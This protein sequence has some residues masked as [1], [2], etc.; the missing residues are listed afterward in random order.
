M[1]Y[2]TGVGARIDRPAA[3]KTGTNEKHED[4]WFAGYTP[5]LATTVWV[6]YT[7][8]EIPMENVHGIAVAGGTFPATIWR[9]FM[10]PALDRVP[11]RAFPQP[12]S[13]PVWKPFTRGRYALSYDPY[14]HQQTYSTTPTTQSTT[15]AS[16]PK[17]TGAG[18]TRRQPGPLTTPNR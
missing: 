7:R 6:G 4:A 10:Q 15:T 2:G 11:H 9:L 16:S 12:D 13:Y 18:T 5:D 14:A 3:G 8:G 1:H 17:Q